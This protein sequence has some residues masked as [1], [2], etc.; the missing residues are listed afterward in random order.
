MKYGKII[1]CMLA[2]LM[3]AGGLGYF[4]DLAYA[5]DEEKVF[6]VGVLGDLESL[7]P[8]LAW[9]EYAWAL[10]PLIYEPLVRWN[11]SGGGDWSIVPGMAESWEWADNGTQVT[12]HLV[13]NAT[14]H[15]GTPFT[16]ADVNWTI[17][18]W[19]WLGWWISSQSHTDHHSIIV[20]DDYTIVFNFVDWGLPNQWRYDGVWDTTPLRYYRGDYNGTPTEIAREY[21]MTTIPY[22][23]IFP[24]HL[25]D[26]L[27]WHD[28]VYGVDSPDYYGYYLENETWIPTSFWDSYWY[29]GISWGVLD[30]TWAE[31]R[32]GTGPFVFDE[33]V[34]GEKVRL[35]ANEDYHY[36]RPHIDA[37]E[38]IT[39]STVETMTQGVVVG[40]IDFCSTSVTFTELADF[41]PNVGVIENDFMGYRML[42]VNQ[43]EDYLNGSGQ[44]DGRGPKH[45]ALLE[46]DVRKAIHQSLDKSRIADV[47][48]LGTARVADSPIH[49][50]LRWHNDAMVEYTYG[51]AAAI[52]TL[53]AAGWTKN[54][55]DLWQKEID[56]VNET[57]SFTLKYVAG[58]PIAFVEA[59]LLEEDIEAT[60]ISITTVPVEASTFVS[61][62]T[63][64]TWNY[65]LATDFWTQ[66]GDPNHYIWYLRS[67]GGLNPN[68]IEI[69][70]IDELFK[71]QQLEPDYT[72]RK[73]L[74]DEFQQ[75]VYDDSSIIPLVYYRDVEVYRSDKWDIRPQD[76]NWTSGVYSVHNQ[77]VWMNLDVAEVTTSPP[78]PLPVEMIVIVAGAAVAI[79]VIVAVVWKKRK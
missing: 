58:D 2:F 55:Q 63:E 47:A 38:F 45:N 57:L 62:M 60:G 28:P 52:A 19:T 32:I 79:V 21:F 25:W 20:P 18:T 65:D 14:W 61:D 69:D 66:L 37:L 17:F 27:M 34:P 51:A 67:D 22:L 56:G 64:G 9:T 35:T 36:G 7:N 71:E 72:A 76:L 11:I 15:D 13:Q 26:P 4:P 31:P 49:D 42:F 41:G 8:I 54:A 6:K 39:Y 70:R 24:M 3:F 43:Y 29:D 46:Q 16:S 10:I 50:S 78:P 23:P 40:D 30:Y 48:Y 74:V 59:Q 53:E 75:I 44:Y 33:W 73:A 77:E 5:Q 12:M 68:N 1:A